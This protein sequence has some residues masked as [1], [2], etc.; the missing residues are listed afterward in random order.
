MSPLTRRNPCLETVA[1]PV[2]TGHRRIRVVQVLATGTN[3]GAQEHLFGL[4]S[5]MDKSRY[6]VSIVALSPGSAARSSLRTALP[7]DRA[8]IETS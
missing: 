4:V 2:P 5:R 7:G 8:T 1:R 3:G 6:D